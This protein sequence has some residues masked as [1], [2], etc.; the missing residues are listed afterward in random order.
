MNILKKLSITLLGSAFAS[1]A[2]IVSANAAVINYATLSEGA[3]IT[4]WSSQLSDSEVIRLQRINGGLDTARN[5]LLSS[6]KTPWL[7]N[8]EPGFIFGNNDENQKL[9]VDLGQNRLIDQIGAH[10]WHYPRDREVWDYFEVRTSLDNLTYTSWGIIGAKDGAVD[11]TEAFNFIERPSQL[12]RY[13]EYDFGRYSFDHGSISNGSRVW[14]LYAN[15]TI[16]T[17][18][19]VPEPS[20]IFSLLTVGAVFA[21]MK[22]KKTE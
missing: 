17:S 14:T 9:I 3:S 13:I 22:R 5:N 10:L 20:S 8:G 1:L 16:E 11:I 18:T 21:K 4:S 7:D 2:S 12:V 15:Q 19:S 6:S